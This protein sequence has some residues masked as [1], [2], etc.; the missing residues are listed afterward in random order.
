METR[1]KPA[2]PW[3]FNFDPNLN[4][5]V[6]FAS[7]ELVWVEPFNM[8]T[9]ARHEEQVS[10]LNVALVCFFAMGMRQCCPS[11]FQR[12]IP[13]SACKRDPPHLLPFSWAP[14]ASFATVLAVPT[15]FVPL[16]LGFFAGPALG[17][18]VALPLPGVREG[19]FLRLDSSEG[20]AKSP[21]N[22]GK[23]L[24]VSSNQLGP[25]PERMTQEQ[26][27]K[28]SRLQVA[29]CVA[30]VFVFL[31][32][33]NFSGVPPP[34]I[35]IYIYTYIHM[36]IYIYIYWRFLF[37]FPCRSTSKIWCTQSEHPIF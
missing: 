26:T 13:Q 24:M 29:G 30:S 32:S 3:W 11:D 6:Q 27:K 21:R 2:G 16:F 19:W 25:G 17:S 1:T 5:P 23:G 28:L 18:V 37:W 15:G 9:K 12:S 7:F 4:S 20:V 35:Y 10:I 31:F 34:N 8:L 36:Y 33:G 14:C 22:F